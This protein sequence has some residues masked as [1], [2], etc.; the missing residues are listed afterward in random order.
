M[1]SAIFVAR[2]FHKIR[3]NEIIARKP[4]YRRDN[5]VMPLYIS[6]RIKFYIVQFPCHSMYF[7]LV[8]ICRLQTV[9]AFS[10]T[11]LKK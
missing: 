7:L 11:F 4:C 5:R 2:V 1:P 8:F 3:Q 6:I 10:L 9:L